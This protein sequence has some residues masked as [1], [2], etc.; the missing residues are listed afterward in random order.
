MPTHLTDESGN[1]RQ[2]PAPYATQAEMEAGT[3]TDERALTPARV[4]QAIAANAVAL[5]S[6]AEA[7][8]GTNNT[9]MMTPLRTSQ[10]IAALGGGGGIAT[11]FSF[12]ATAQCAD[13]TALINQI[14]TATGIP[15]SYNA[16]IAFAIKVGAGTHLHFV[17]RN[18]SFGDGEDGSYINASA[19]SATR[20][21]Q[22]AITYP[23]ANGTTIL[24]YGITFS[25]SVGG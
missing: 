2:V 8:A 17:S 9:K 11:P 23:I 7:E 4:K 19:T 22:V 18:G 24:V 3:G 14:M 15:T 13:A 5:A 10:A 21:Q 25:P 16:N 1:L 20:A 12:Q 6:Q